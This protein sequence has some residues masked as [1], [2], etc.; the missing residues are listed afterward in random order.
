[1]VQHLNLVVAVLVKSLLKEVGWEMR[2]AWILVVKGKKTCDL[3]MVENLNV[4]VAYVTLTEM[5]PSLLK[6]SLQQGWNLLEQPGILKDHWEW[7]NY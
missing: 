7:E 2:V 4:V 5:Q 1:M 6:L 3:S